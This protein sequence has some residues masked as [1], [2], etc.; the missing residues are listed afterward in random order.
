MGMDIDTFKKIVKMVECRSVRTPLQLCLDSFVFHALYTPA[1]FQGAS[2]DLI[3]LKMISIHGMYQDEMWIMIFNR[4]KPSFSVS[5]STRIWY[6]L[7]TS[8]LNKNQNTNWTMKL[9]WLSLR[10]P[11]FKRFK[12]SNLGVYFPNGRIAQMICIFITFCLWSNVNSD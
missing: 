6:I 2:S 5:E 10:A 9:C 11:S 12:M 8:P 7:Q 4:N 1:E 3:S